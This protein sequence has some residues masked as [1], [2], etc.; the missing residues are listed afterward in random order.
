MKV[1]VEFKRRRDGQRGRGILKKHIQMIE[2][3][4]FSLNSRMNYT[5]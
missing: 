2:F 1:P 5:D 3:F 4:K